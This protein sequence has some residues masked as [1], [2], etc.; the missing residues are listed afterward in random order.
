MASQPQG[1]KTVLDIRT[2]EQTFQELMQ[3]EKPR[4]RWTLKLD[5]KLEP[6]CLA[7]GWKQYQQ[8]G[9]GRFQCSSCRRN[10]A[11]AQVHILCHMHLEPQKS[12]G[13]VIMRLFAQRCQKCSWSR[14][15]NPEFSPESAMRIL[16]NV[17]RRILEK[18][19]GNGFR[20][21]P[22]LP[23]I[24]EVPL[25]GSHDTKNCEACT[26]GCCSWRSRNNETEPSISPSSSMD[27][28]SSSCHI[29]DMSGQNQEYGSNY[30]FK[31][32]GPS[33]TTAET[34]AP[35]AGTQPKG[36][37]SR[38]PTP[39]ADRQA[40]QENSQSTQETA[41]QTPWRTYSEVLRMAHQQSTQQSFSQATWTMSRIISRSTIES[42]PQTRGR[43][44]PS[45]LGSHLQLTRRTARG[46]VILSRTQAT[47]RRSPR[48]SIPNTHH[49]YPHSVQRDV[50]FDLDIFF[51]F[52]VC[53]ILFLVFVGKY[54][55]AEKG[56]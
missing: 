46:L 16:K 1:G 47:W 38:Q 23:I 54:S 11:S 49:I 20:K 2:W 7:E 29:G 8:K 22:E 34:Q 31:E 18:F 28:R 37:T 44:A 33:H 3:Q 32:S 45:T 19:Y 53:I 42:Y 15:E 10:W 27:I 25:D 39:M 5:E 48:Y 50:F 51:Y 35:E 26:L 43:T 24:R 6:D 41:P 52:C 36:E 56:K 13:Q 40:I 55:E 17:V 4:A 21:F 30:N 12:Q 9:F 14:F